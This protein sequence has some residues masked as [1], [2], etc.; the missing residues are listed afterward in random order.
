MGRQPLVQVKG[1]SEERGAAFSALFFIGMT[2]DASRPASLSARMG[3]HRMIRLGLSSPFA[4]SQC[5]ASAADGAYGA[6]GISGDGID[7]AP[8]YPSIIHATPDNFGPGAVSGDHRHS[9]GQRLSGIDFL[10]RR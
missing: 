1:V 5:A 10:C 8:I 3:D 7:C 4:A 9:D 6:D 2:V